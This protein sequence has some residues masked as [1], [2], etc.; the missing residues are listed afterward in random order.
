MKKNIQ[1]HID[2]LKNIKNP[3]IIASDFKNNIITSKMTIFTSGLISIIEFSEGAFFGK[4]VDEIIHNIDKKIF[5]KNNNS[6]TY[7]F[8]IDNQINDN[9]P[10]YNFNIDNQINDNKITKND[11][12]IIFITYLQL[13]ITGCIVI[14]LRNFNRSIGLGNM[15]K[16]FFKSNYPPP[17]AL[18]FGIWF[19]QNGLKERVN[20]LSKKHNKIFI[21]IPICIIFLIL[22]FYFYD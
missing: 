11:L 5:L 16:I 19:Y 12:K 7:N 9:S 13:F 22:T 15:K 10:N 1:K 18:S 4:L 3:T 8:N 14:I 2:N 21:I 6:L 17:V 20:Y